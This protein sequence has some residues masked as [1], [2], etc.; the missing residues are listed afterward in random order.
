MWIYIST[1]ES[2]EVSN[3]DLDSALV[4][5]TVPYVVE[6][7]EYFV[8]YGVEET[9]LNFTTDIISGNDNTSLTY[10]TYSTTLRNLT[11]GTDYYVQ[12]TAVFSYYTLY[13]DTSSFTT[14][15][16]GIILYLFVL[17]L[18]HNFFCTVFRTFST[19]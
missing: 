4:S 11:I 19:N 16:Q 10:Q 9:S 8:V 18:L 1:L 5:W 2:I 3:I 6:P 7:Q 14:L 17:T 15:E 12:V 13:S